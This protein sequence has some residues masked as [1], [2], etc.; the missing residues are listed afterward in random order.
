M[1]VS[2]T[3]FVATTY[4]YRV[5]AGCS[6]LSSA[7]TK[8]VNAPNDSFLSFQYHLWMTDRKTLRVLAYFD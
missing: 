3:H 2:G 7:N 5:V 4:M 1:H 6:N 8:M